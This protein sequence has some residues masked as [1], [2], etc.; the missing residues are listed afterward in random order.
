MSDVR[1]AQT[2]LQIPR[3]LKIEL[4]A[5]GWPHA[6]GKLADVNEDLGSAGQGLNEAE[7]P[8]FIPFDE[9]AGLAH[10]LQFKPSPIY[11]SEGLT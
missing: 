4:G 11:M 10:G 8:R 9:P 1:G 2:V 5:D 7:S 6:R 3:D